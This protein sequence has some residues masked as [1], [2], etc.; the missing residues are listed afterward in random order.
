MKPI[1]VLLFLIW[2]VPIFAQPVG[3]SHLQAHVPDV[4]DFRAFFVRDASDF[5]S[6]KT[7]KKVSAEYELL[8]EGATQ[9]G[10]AFPKFYAWVRALGEDKGVL[11]EGAMRVAAIEK[12][13]FQVTDFLTREE[14]VA[15]P[16][17]I[18]EMFPRALLPRI[19][20]KAGVK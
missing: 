8:R 4:K 20:E 15:A 9:S 14:I 18:E 7:G 13:R 1:F 19:R 10:V 3:E 11:C 6:K 17:R 16:A 12:K 2:P 5:L